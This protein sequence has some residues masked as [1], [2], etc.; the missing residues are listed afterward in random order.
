MKLKQSWFGSV[1]HEA[2]AGLVEQHGMSGPEVEHIGRETF[3]RYHSGDRT[4]SI[5]CEPGVAPIV[6]LFYRPADAG[7]KIVPWAERNGIQ[8]TRRIPRLEVSEPFSPTSAETYRS[9][10]NALAKAFLTQEAKYLAGT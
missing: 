10:I 2:F 6:E 4:V 7:E 8:R 5:S 1:C 9:Y 3:V